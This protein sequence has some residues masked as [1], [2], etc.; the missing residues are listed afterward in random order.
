MQ[1]A[2][3]A[4]EL[5]AVH[6]KEVLRVGPLKHVALVRVKTQDEYALEHRRHRLALARSNGA[7][8]SG[9]VAPSHACHWHPA[10]GLIT[11]AAALFTVYI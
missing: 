1:A 8:A 4:L 10:H 9:T 7:S 2:R 5:D 6:A 11:P 3:D